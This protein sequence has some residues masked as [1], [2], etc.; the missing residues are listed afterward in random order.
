MSNPEYMSHCFNIPVDICRFLTETFGIMEIRGIV[1]DWNSVKFEIRS[2]ET[3]HN[4]PHV[5]ASY[6]EYNVSIDILTLETTGNL[7][8]KKKKSAIK[9]VEDNQ[10]YLLNKWNTIAMSSKLPMTKSALDFEKV[11]V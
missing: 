8:S 10:D 4:N 2:K 5:H 1:G 9:W 6:G 7:P 3:P 11:E